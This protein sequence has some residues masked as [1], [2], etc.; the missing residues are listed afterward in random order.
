MGRKKKRPK[1]KHG[2][3]KLSQAKRDK[4]FDAWCERQSVKHVSKKCK[5]HW[6]TASRYRK[7]EFDNWDARYAKIQEEANAKADKKITNKLAER[8]QSYRAIADAGIN[9]LVR[10][11]REQQK[12]GV[13]CPEL[14]NTI[15]EQV[16][17][18]KLLELL[19]GRP[20]SRPD[21]PVDDSFDPRVDA[22]IEFLEKKLGEKG[23]AKLADKL[24]DGL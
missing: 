14:E 17:L 8:I 9:R 24:A 15:S 20:D 5:V 23:L 10:K 3:I 1:K 7:P 18:E 6:N 12:K 22:A 19:E 21:K 4:M 13:E 11:I 2:P 16:A